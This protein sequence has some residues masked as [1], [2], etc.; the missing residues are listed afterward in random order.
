MA[1]WVQDSVPLITMPALQYPS[2]LFL[3][4]S[5]RRT[6]WNASEKCTWFSLVSARNPGPWCPC[7]PGPYSPGPI[8]TSMFSKF[9][10]ISTRFLR[11][12]QA[13]GKAVTS[14][15]CIFLQSD[16]SSFSAQSSSP[17]LL[18]LLF[19]LNSNSP[20]Y[21]PIRTALWRDSDIPHQY[22]D[23]S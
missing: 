2:P 6:S 23:V 13:S 20:S 17:A 18:S 9:G 15:V 5:P 19:P 11:L 12:V 22:S 21:L 14:A 3:S 10:R 4:S 7:V 16:R 8:F 1:S